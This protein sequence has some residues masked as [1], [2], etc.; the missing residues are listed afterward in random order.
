MLP[1]F[2]QNSSRKAIQ[3][4]P[5]AS[6]EF[7]AWLSQQAPEQVRF[8]EAVGFKAQS[9]SFCPLPAADGTVSQFVVGYE[10]TDAIWAFANLALTLPEGVYQWGALPT[11]AMLY[12]AIVAWGLGA[13]QFARYKKPKRAPAQLLLPDSPLSQSAVDFVMAAYA[14]RHWINTPAQD[15]NPVT[16]AAA[17][18]ERA[19]TFAASYSEIVGDD[20]LAQGYHAVHAVGRA[21]VHAPRL[22]VFEAGKAE[23]PL[24]C[25]VGKG[26]CFDTG[27]LDVKPS[28]NM[29]LMKKD[30]GG[31]A[32]ALGLA[33]LILQAKLPVRLQVFIPAVENA[34]AGNA[35]RPSDVIDTY[36]GKTVE[37]GNTDAE[38]RLILADA[39]AKAAEGNPDLMIDFATLTGA[40]RIA[41]GTDVPMYFTNDEVLAESLW[42]TAQQ[43][44][45][46]V[47]RMPLYAPYRQHLDSLIAD[48]NNVAKTS[49][50][51]AIHAA[52]FLQEFVPAQ[53]KWMHVDLMAWN[54]NPRPGRPEGGEAMGLRTIFESIKARYSAQ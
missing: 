50:G 20:L 53:T 22:C 45:E 13:Y 48:M 18:A 28:A 39:L 19:Q 2:C 14:V 38:G 25:I 37:I 21:S 41:L 4:I 3:L 1:C 24:L 10:S 52:L 11:D 43:T 49:F 36:A 9:Q 44:G 23:W 40:A 15:M 5:V 32:H 7:A 16:L 51:G 54:S 34:V 6:H 31:A 47:W 33:Q 8:I 27:G 12:N 17:V 29:L 46:L 42:L 35:F 26:V 30:M